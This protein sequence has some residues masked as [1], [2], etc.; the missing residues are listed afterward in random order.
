MAEI[1]ENCPAWIPRGW[2]SSQA[3]LV[4][5]DLELERDEKSRI[6]RLEKKKRW[7]VDCLD[8]RFDLP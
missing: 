2:T 5:I 8:R 4:E 7:E 1:I 6:I 3:E